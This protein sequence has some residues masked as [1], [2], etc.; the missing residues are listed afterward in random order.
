MLNAFVGRS[1]VLARFDAALPAVPFALVIGIAGVGKTALVARFAGAWPGDVIVRSVNRARPGAELFAE[2][3]RALAHE[4]D[5]VDDLDRLARA[6]DRRATLLVIEDADRLDGVGRALLTDLVSR[7]SVAR[8]IAT[9]RSHLYAPG[10]GPERLQIVLDGLEHSAA[11]ELWATLDLLYG[12]RD[13]FEAAWPRSHGNP[14]YLRRAHAGDRDVELVLAD[15]WASLPEDDRAVALALCVAERAVAPQVVA[16]LLP[17]GRG[18]RACARLAE[19]L[20]IEASGDEL[21]LHA[22]LRAAVRAAASPADLS[23]AHRRLAEAL[24]DAGIDP[25]VEVRERVRHLLASGQRGAARALVLGRARELVRLGGSGELLSCLDALQPGWR[26]HDAVDDPELGHLRAR[27]LTRMLEIRRAYDAL[28]QL[29]APVA[30]KA[31]RASFAQLALVTGRLEVAERVTR[32]ALAHN[33]AEPALTIRNAVTWLLAR[34]CQG[35]GEA[36]RAWS[37]DLA[38]DDPRGR[39]TIAL[40]CAVSCGLEQRGAE[41]EVH[42][43][44]A[45]ASCEPA[46]RAVA[47]A[48]VLA[49]AGKL[50]AAQ[51][52]VVAGEPRREDPLIAVM[53][54]AVRGVLHASRGAHAAALE[55]MDAAHRRFA[56]AGHAIAALWTQL[57]RGKLLLALGRAREGHAVLDD[58][59]GQALAVDAQLI[60][61]QS[62][63]ARLADPRRAVREDRRPLPTC[64]GERRRD[65]VIAALRAL[66]DHRLALAR[67]HLVRLTNP[68]GLDALE[69]ALVT[70]ATATLARMTGDA[71]APALLDQAIELAARAGADPELVVELDAWLRER[72]AG[73]TTSVEIDRTRHAVQIAGQPVVALASR[74][75]LRRLL[76]ALADASG[77]SVDKARL[78]MAIWPGKYRPARHDSALWVN[79][80]RLRDLLSGTG[81]RIVTEPTGYSIVAETGFRLVC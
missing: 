43:R 2:L 32:T 33:H 45:A 20:L 51:A 57:Q 75:A 49:L 9:A 15:T 59:A 14:A 39:G 64:P 71:H 5:G 38:L 13:G 35:H 34:T 50:D 42:L 62:E 65:R 47:E 40:A 26:E 18:E 7:I 36:A 53:R 66:A 6:L 55:A 41:A 37:S 80:K 3:G 63:D 4:A 69:H 12:V 74:P 19:G 8:V 81:L 29:S 70:L 60:A 73:T 68:D 72:G 76:Y 54:C 16:R 52:T 67:G 24:A 28:A 11:A 17:D 46:L 25:I 21:A 78:A 79:L 61:R 48:F 77:A 56:E 23:D 44:L 22:L 30:S 10:E 31:V 1:L 27:V 58:V